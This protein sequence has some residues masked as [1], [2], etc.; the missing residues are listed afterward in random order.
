MGLRAYGVIR[1]FGVKGLEI[2]VLGWRLRR[3]PAMLYLLTPKPQTP[4]LNPATVKTNTNPKPPALSG[5]V[6]PRLG[7]RE[8]PRATL[9]G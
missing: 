9:A 4:T 5:F 3:T 8:S 6:G 1:D 2:G 7:R